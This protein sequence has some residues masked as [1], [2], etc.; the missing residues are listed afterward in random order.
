MSLFSAGLFGPDIPDTEDFE[1]NDL[2]GTYNGETGKFD[3]Q[4]SLVF[5]GTYSLAST[6]T[7]G[8]APTI[9]HEKLT[10]GR[11][12]KTTVK[13]AS[14]P[15]DWIQEYVYGAQSVSSNANGYKVS[16]NHGGPSM[17]LKEL[18]TGNNIKSTNLSQTPAGGT[19]H[20]LQ[21]KWLS[22]GTHDIQFINNS[23]TNLG[24]FSVVDNTYT[25]GNIGFEYD[26]GASVTQYWDL[27]ETSD[28]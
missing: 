18:S 6:D 11:D 25:E 20:T 21:I 22:D 3:I 19:Y 14:D 2:T 10:H 23:G 24:G 12:T 13:V 15:S 26:I 16:I 17:A 7:S 28:I 8:S 1:H 5:S 9:I 27:I 4:T